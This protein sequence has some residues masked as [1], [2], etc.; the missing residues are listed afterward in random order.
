MSGAPFF[1]DKMY[2][3]NRRTGEAEFFAE[4]ALGDDADAITFVGCDLYM[5]DAVGQEE[6]SYL[7]QYDVEQGGLT[8]RR[9]VDKRLPV[10]L[11]WD[12]VQEQL[13]GSA[14]DDRQVLRMPLRTDGDDVVLGITHALG[15][16]GDNSLGGL[17]AVEECDG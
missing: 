17:V 8:F 16:Y 2:R 5:L 11:A 1:A 10:D 4:V 3:L 15:H 13:Y 14:S 12:P 6:K 9:Y 7:S